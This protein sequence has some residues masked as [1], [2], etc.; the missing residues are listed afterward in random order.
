MAA[1]VS[2]VAKKGTSVVVR[3]FSNLRSLRHS[4]KNSVPEWTP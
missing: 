4:T 1:H 2:A 3:A